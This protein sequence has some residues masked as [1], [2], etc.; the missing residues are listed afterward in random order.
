[1]SARDVGLD[2][3]KAAREIITPP[4]RALYYPFQLPKHVD[5]DQEWDAPSR[6]A[7]PGVGA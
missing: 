7:S 6:A 1:M 3:F 4:E 2:I 5:W